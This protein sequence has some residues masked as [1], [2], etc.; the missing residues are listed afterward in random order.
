[1]KS[2]IFTASHLG[3]SKVKVACYHFCFLL[4]ACGSEDAHQ[5]TN[6]FTHHCFCTIEASID[7][8]KRA[9]NILV[10][11]EKQ[12]WFCR[13]PERISGT[14]RGIPTYTSRNLF[15]QVLHNV[16]MYYLISVP[17]DY[18]LLISSPQIMLQPKTSSGCHFVE[19]SSEEKVLS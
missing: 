2:I 3:R 12:S 17:I 14:L 11:L 19:S 1:M 13:P 6:S 4:W 16:G 8:V 10:I 7:K 5:D 9:S 15:L 18:L